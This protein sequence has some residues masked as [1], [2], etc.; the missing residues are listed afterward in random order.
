MSAREGN[1]LRS[2]LSGKV[3]AVKTI[4]DG[5]AVLESLDGSSQVWTERD[6]LNLFYERVE[7][8]F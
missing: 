6:N 2:I 5:A 1:K 8:K 4:K 3:Y 7:R